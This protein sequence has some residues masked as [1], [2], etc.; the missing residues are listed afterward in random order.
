[1]TSLFQIEGNLVALRGLIEASNET[2]EIDPELCNWLE[3]SEGEFNLKVESYCGVIGELL[4][5][6]EAR[7]SEVAR[8]TVLQRL[9]EKRAKSLKDSLKRTFHVLGVID[10]ETTRYRV[11]VRKAGGMLPLIIEGDVPEGYQQAV[12]QNNTAAIRDALIAGC[13]LG[14][15]RLGERSDVLVIS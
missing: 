9:A 8:L 4:A 14:F 11:R 7:K 12:M 6:A 3:N 15:A 10:V 5:V 1:M 2:G 13:Q